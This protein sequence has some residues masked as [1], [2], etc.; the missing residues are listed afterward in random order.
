MNNTSR[1]AALGTTLGLT[2]TALLASKVGATENTSTQPNNTAVYNAVTDGGCVPDCKQA[3]YTD[4]DGRPRNPLN[5]RIMSGTD[6]T[7]KINALIKKASDNGGGIIFF[8]PGNYLTGTIV[9]ESNISLVGSGVD[10]TTLS[11][12]DGANSS[13]VTNRLAD[14]FRGNAYRVKVSDMTIDG[15]RWGQ[16]LDWYKKKPTDFQDPHIDQSYGI[17]LHRTATNLDGDI[18]SYSLIQNVRVIFT[19][20]SGI[21]TK[22]HGGETRIINCSTFR[23]GGYGIVPGWDSL[24]MASTTG[25]SDFAGF[26]IHHGQSE[27]LG[28]KSFFSGTITTRGMRGG[29]GNAG[30]KAPGFIVGSNGHS[31]LTGIRSQNNGGH[32]ILLKDATS[33]RVWGIADANNM[34]ATD[35]GK[36][37]AVPD[38]YDD[39]KRVPASVTKD[40]VLPDASVGVALEGKC[41]GNDINLTTVTSQAQGGQPFGWQK[42][43]V[44]ISG[45]SYMNTIRVNQSHGRVNMGRKGGTVLHP[46][47]PD[48][49]RQRNVITDGWGNDQGKLSDA[50]TAA[51]EESKRLPWVFEKDREAYAQ[52]RRE[53][54]DA[55]TGKIIWYSSGRR[56][57]VDYDG[58]SISSGV[59]FMKTL[60]VI[61]RADR[62]GYERDG[63]VIIDRD[64]DK[65][66]WYSS[67]KRRWLDSNGKPA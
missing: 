45:D 27:V 34:I 17:L 29:H 67:R 14:S 65:I 25:K 21:H 32:G 37:W 52:D 3:T 5:A 15:N 44:L 8:P 22:E 1:R 20:S 38:E 58:N 46:A 54:I 7:E 26:Y 56:S 63:S 59:P 57:W 66:L 51:I 11:L 40:Y 39:S 55:A 12:K 47:T 4:K 18:D 6:N 2:A 16:T 62:K 42:H 33:V 50:I 49:A 35:E 13:V 53:I 19:W 30:R 64:T 10:I 24:T 23:A 41:W 48:V 9:L 28:C 36:W 61:S 31:N 60:P 43:P